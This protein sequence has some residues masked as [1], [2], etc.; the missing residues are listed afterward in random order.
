[1]HPVS[2]GGNYVLNDIYYKSNSA[3]LEQISI[4]VVK[5]FA[6]YMQANAGIKVKIAGY[7]DNVGSDAA[8][9]ALSSN[10]A[11]TV[12]QALI[13]EGIE[14]ARL[15]Y[16]GYGAANPVASNDTEEGRQKNRRTEFVIT[17]Q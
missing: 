15:N 9:Q 14:P 10:R 2:A 12:M 17:Q 13:K 3:Q 6:K 7:T 5:E 1:M 8:N 16:Q 11:S 4:A